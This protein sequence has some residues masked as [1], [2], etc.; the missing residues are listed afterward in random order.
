MEPIKNIIHDQAKSYRNLALAGTVA[1]IV[2]AAVFMAYLLH[3][4]QE[5]LSRLKSQTTTSEGPEISSVISELKKQ[6][7]QEEKY[8]AENNE[9][10]ILVLKAVDV[11]LSFTVKQERTSAG[12]LETKLTAV[13]S[14]TTVSS[15]RVQKIVLHLNPAQ[16][17]IAQFS[18]TDGLTDQP[19][20]PKQRR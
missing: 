8:A 14:T 15:E 4:S 13:T 20:A 2:A 9:A 7:A 16:P 19:P 3:K 5:E 17:R 6:I 12:T 11:E 1:S 18:G 10:D